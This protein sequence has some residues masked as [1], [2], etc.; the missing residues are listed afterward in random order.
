[1]DKRPVEHVII[2]NGPAGIAAAQA[3]REI[4]THCAITI[5]TDED[6]PGYSRVL[7][8]H[9]IGEEIPAEHLV[10]KDL[11]FYHDQG[12]TLV[13]GVRVE[14]VDLDSQL[15]FLQD[16]QKKLY[17]QLLIATGA[18]P[19]YPPIS[20][21]HTKGVFPLRT[22]QHA[23]SILQ[24]LTP[25]GSVLVIGGGM[26]SLNTA[27]ALLTR[28]TRVILFEVAPQLLPQNMDEKAA[29]IVEAHLRDRG[30]E[31]YTSS[32]VEKIEDADG[33]LIVSVKGGDHFTGDS[34]IVGTGVMTNVELA[35]ECGIACDRGILVD[36]RMRTNVPG[37]YAAGDVAQAKDFL[38]EENM[39]NPLWP[40]AV[41]QGKVA[42]FNMAGGSRE[43][44]GN[45]S[46]NSANFCGLPVMS[47]GLS[48]V[49]S[50][51]YTELV[52]ER[53][54]VFHK[55]VIADGCLIG[56]VLV[57]EVDNAGI[58]LSYIR[59][60]IVLTK[61]EALLPGGERLRRLAVRSHYNNRKSFF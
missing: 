27:C 60:K 28:G 45:I 3:I 20:G 44:E 49:R 4:D 39:L 35:Q 55:L 2:G 58:Y 52:W 19:V 33:K 59:E 51:R 7:L 36:S 31:I 61:P 21:I 40:T 46:A 15:I 11:D 18:R 10:L 37:V 54:H 24:H 34:V 47:M 32:M 5:L 8:T 23:R 12:V 22:V 9:Y 50:E 13:K 48:N 14:R 57:G 29:A 26:V 43:Y 38:R 41:A 42:G 6:M 30:M 53:D 56:V 17:D 1:M 16:G 25:G